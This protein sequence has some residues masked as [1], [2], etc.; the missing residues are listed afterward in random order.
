MSDNKFFTCSNLTTVNLG[1]LVIL[2]IQNC[3]RP[4]FSALISFIN[5]SKTHPR[6]WTPIE[7]SEFNI[8]AS[9]D[10][11]AFCTCFGP[12]GLQLATALGAKVKTYSGPTVRN[13]SGHII[14][15][16]AQVRLPIKVVNKKKYIVAYVANEFDYDCVLG[17]DKHRKFNA[18]IDPEK[19]ILLLD[20]QETIP[21]EF[22]VTGRN[23]STCLA[24]LRPTVADE[25]ESLF[26]EFAP[27]VHGPSIGCTHLMEHTIE[28]TSTKPI[29]QKYYPVSQKLEE[30]MHAEVER[31]LD[32]DI[33]EP[34]TSSWFSQVVLVKKND[35]KYRFC[36]DYCKI[37]SVTNISARTMPHMDSILRKL[38]NA[39][40][41]ST[42]DLS[43][44]FN[45]VPLK[46][47]HKHYTL[48]TSLIWPFWLTWDFP[49]ING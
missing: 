29:K 30:V 48:Q 36:V 16:G 38:R 25:I 17:A 26:D 47:E 40:Y 45:Q 20:R 11:G 15:I 12:V 7:I 14:S 22:D 6:W 31:M 46:K 5:A 4:S 34:S 1:E 37:N 9:M 44:A 19:H 24:A 21:L 43:M 42:I 49:K 27:V 39:K 23:E 33:I 32:Q 3:N 41:M 8:R 18:M 2:E 28:V 10:N 13:A 35:N